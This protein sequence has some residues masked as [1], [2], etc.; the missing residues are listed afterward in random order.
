MRDVLLAA[1]L[2][3][4]LA[5]CQ[6]V[7]PPS[8]ESTSSLAGKNILG[9][10]RIPSASCASSSAS[11]SLAS[12]SQVSRASGSAAASLASSSVSSVSLLE[13][14]LELLRVIGLRNPVVFVSS[15]RQR[16][17]FIA[18]PLFLSRVVF[19]GAPLEQ[20]AQLC[21]FGLGR[22]VLFLSV[23]R[24]S[25]QQPRIAL[26]QSTQVFVA[27]VLCAHS[28][29]SAHNSSSSISASRPSSFAYKQKTHS[30]CI[31]SSSASVTSTLGAFELLFPLE[32]RAVGPLE[33]HKQQ[34]VRL[35]HPQQLL[36]LRHSSA[37]SALR[38]TVSPVVSPHQ[39]LFFLT[40]ATSSAP[41]SRRHHRPRARASSW[42]PRLPAAGRIPARVPLQFKI[43][44]SGALEIV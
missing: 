41:S 18:A 28:S 2:H 13:R 36:L 21:V 20:R 12:T 10:L 30:S 3:Y 24:D 8:T 4:L 27:V 33:H 9:A 39:Q 15:L 1:Y 44:L 17:S 38:S 25:L 23:I 7:C 14:C 22:P 29:S 40:R 19:L 11:P 32:L 42:R 31:R 5:P 37:S 26:E 35:E 16:T 43:H 34:L 6:A